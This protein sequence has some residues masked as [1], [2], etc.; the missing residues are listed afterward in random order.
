V[1]GEDG[2]EDQNIEFGLVRPD[3]DSWAHGPEIVV[4]I[5]DLDRYACGVAHDELEGAR[6]DI[7]SGV[8]E[9]EGAEDDGGDD[10]V[11]GAG[12]EAEV[13]CEQARWERCLRHRE[14]QSIEEDGEGDGE[15]EG[16]QDPHENGIHGGRSA[17]RAIEVETNALYHTL[18]LENLPGGTEK[19]HIGVRAGWER[20]GM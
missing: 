10:A 18:Y 17:M 1:C 15:E 20:W 11:E 9:A 19:A 3:E 5:V 6:D 2:A 4:G 12:N 7:L 8:L 13:G 14:R 16:I